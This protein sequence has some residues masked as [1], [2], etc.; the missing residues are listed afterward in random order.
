MIKY[1]QGKP[2]PIVIVGK[3]QNVTKNKKYGNKP[4]LLIIV[5]NDKQSN[6]FLST[7]LT[8]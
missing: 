2:T 5:D 7:I 4:L 3:L 6:N 1:S 8:D